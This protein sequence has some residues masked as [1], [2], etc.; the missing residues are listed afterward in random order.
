MKTLKPTVALLTV[1]L[2]GFVHSRRATATQIQIDLGGTGVVSDSLIRSFTNN[3]NGTPFQGQNLPIDF[4]FQ[5]GEFIRLFTATDRNLFTMDT[6][7]RIDNAPSSISFSGS[8]YLVDSHGDPASTPRSLA[9][10]PVTNGAGQ[11]TGE[12]IVL[13][14][15]VTNA[16]PIDFYGFH[17]DLTLPVSP[18]FGFTD[19]IGDIT[20]ANGTIFGVGP[21]IPADIVPE[22]GST[23]WLS[24]IALG[25]LFGIRWLFYTDALAASRRR[26]LSGCLA[27][28]RAL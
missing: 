3:L 22:T 5:N 14:P 28:T 4:T 12:D 25:T 21:G 20:F 13:F 11:V 17:L 10:F 24:T 2:I 16:P 23:F 19:P 18:G 9:T 26:L 6:F 1:F 7:V 15:Q 27:R 8:G